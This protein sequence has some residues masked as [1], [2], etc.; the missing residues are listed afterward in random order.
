MRLTIG[1]GG[2]RPLPFLLL[3]ALIP[4][5]I[6]LVA[7]EE[8]L[9]TPYTAEQI[10]DAWVQEF[11]VTTRPRSA[12][13]EVYSRTTVEAWTEQGFAM[14]EITVDDQGRPAPG[15]EVAHYTGTWED[16][17]DH[18]KFPVSTATRARADRDTPLGHLEGWLYRVQGAKGV[19]EYFF[20][21]DLPGPPVVYRREGE[22]LE[23]FVAEQV[24]RK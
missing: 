23:G 12:A 4:L 2:A 5:A 16:L 14:S 3:L 22:G 1:R 8:F 21:D 19:T 18:A 17:R 10:R 6:P 13:G 9:P 24:L 20:A 7:E 15:E 11:E